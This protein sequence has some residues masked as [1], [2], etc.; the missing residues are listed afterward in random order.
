ME[1]RYIPRPKVH[2]NQCFSML[3]WFEVYI[4]IFI[5]KLKNYSQNCKFLCFSPKKVFLR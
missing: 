4:Y 5:R 1:Y 2:K 3:L